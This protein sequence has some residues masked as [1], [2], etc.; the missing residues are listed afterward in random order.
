MKVDKLGEVV[1]GGKRVGIYSNFKEVLLNEL[2]R[3]N[4]IFDMG[5]ERGCAVF[6]IGIGEKGKV[7]LVRERVVLGKMGDMVVTV[8]QNLELF[9]VDVYEEVD[10]VDVETFLR[11]VIDVVGM[12]PENAILVVVG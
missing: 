12:N 6:K 1:I 4:V 9:D 5:K 10:L 7:Y 2:K 8:S 3:A 11:K